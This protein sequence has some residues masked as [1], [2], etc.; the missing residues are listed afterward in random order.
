M[1]KVF[2]SGTLDQ[3]NS[4]VQIQCEDKYTTR[5]GLLLSGTFGPA[6]FRFRSGTPSLSIGHKT[7]TFSPVNGSAVSWATSAVGLYYLEHSFSDLRFV[8]ESED[9]TTDIDWVLFLRPRP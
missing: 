1:P 2:A 4:S 6:T 9:G 8:L 3:A 7:H 5:V